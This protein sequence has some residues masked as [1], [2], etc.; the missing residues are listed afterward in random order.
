[1]TNSE[2]LN[3]VCGRK[4]PNY[5]YYNKQIA[6]CVIFIIL[7]VQSDNDTKKIAFL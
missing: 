2:N 6:Q 5:F 4:N 3:D 1:M 7:H